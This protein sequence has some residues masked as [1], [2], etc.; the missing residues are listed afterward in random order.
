MTNT[1]CKKC[2]ELKA[3]HNNLVPILEPDSE[4]MGRIKQEQLE[5]KKD[6]VKFLTKD[7]F[8][9]YDKISSIHYCYTG[10]EYN[11]RRN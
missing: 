6:Y 9:G 11:I 10:C 1:I 3:K 7:N 8:V 2:A 4:E 5:L